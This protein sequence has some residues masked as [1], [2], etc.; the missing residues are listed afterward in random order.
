MLYRPTSAHTP[1]QPLRPWVPIETGGRFYGVL[2][3]KV[4]PARQPQPFMPLSSATLLAN[5]CALLFSHLETQALLA[6]LYQPELV[7][8]LLTPREQEVL[9]LLCQGNEEQDIADSLHI[10]LKTMKK[11]RENLY[12]KLRVRNAQQ[13]RL[14][15]FANGLYTPLSSLTP[16][17][18]NPFEER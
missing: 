15:A 12:R 16:H 6:G 8:T 18:G 13:L 9:E 1:T 4:D 14:A 3:L 11:H 17:I 5:F 7:R 2:L 10:T